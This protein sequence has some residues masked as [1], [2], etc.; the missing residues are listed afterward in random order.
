MKKNKKQGMDFFMSVLQSVKAKLVILLIGISTVSTVLV[1]G[2][3]IFSTVQDNKA[4]NEEY[5]QELAD[6]FD[7]ELRLQTEGLVSALDAV[8]VEQKSG[9]ITETQAKGQAIALIK[10]DRFDDGNGYFFAD[11]MQGQCVAHATLG[12][13]VEGKM[14]MNDKDA[15]GVYYMQEI[16]KAAKSNDGGGFSDFSF[17]KPNETEGTPKRCF[18]MVFKPYGWVIATGAW[19]DHMEAAAKVHEEKNAAALQHKVVIS[20]VILAV[21]E[22]LLL[23]LSF[24]LARTFSDPLQASTKQLQMFAKGDF[25]ELSKDIETDRKDEFGEMEQAIDILRQ[26]MQGLVLTI[27][28]SADEVTADASHLSKNTEQ[29]AQVSNQIATSITGVAESAN[30]QLEAVSKTTEVIEELSSGMQEMSASAGEAAAS[31]K[32]ATTKAREGSQVIEDAMQQMNSV[33]TA[34]NSSAKVIHKLGERSQAIGEIVDTISGIAGQTNLL[35]LNAAIEAARA[36]E[37]GRGFAVV[38]EEVRKLAEQS[39]EATEKIASLIGEIQKDTESAVA[40]MQEGTKQVQTGTSV[41]NTA[42]KS[43]LEIVSLVDDVAAQSSTIAATIEKMTA[44]T[45]IMVSSVRNINE[46]NKGVASEAE[47]VSAATE[48]QT[49]AISEMSSSSQRLVEMAETLQMAIQELKV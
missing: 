3:F 39:Q 44:H 38:A 49:A 5:R 14:R 2:Y 23:G 19:V 24:R 31:A 45:G 30:K 7:R 37:Q 9:R 17:P 15:Q 42:G 46:M 18:S 27:R 32:E 35:A 21:I 25:S 36:G 26:T 48:E 20:I 43:F 13:K 33:E 8:Y 34:V 47:N 40:S 6:H 29:S 16:F 22:V 10:A 12:A 11:D 4:V 28:E 1:G 41:V